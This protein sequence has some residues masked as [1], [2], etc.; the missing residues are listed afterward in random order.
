MMNSSGVRYLQKAELN[1]EVLITGT[2][3]MNRDYKCLYHQFIMNKDGNNDGQWLGM[4]SEL[5]RYVKVENFQ[6]VKKVEKM[7]NLRVNELKLSMQQ[8][9][10]SLEIKLNEMVEE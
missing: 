3:L 4:M 8:N 6:T 5:K 9:F 10:N 2:S 7:V 1:I